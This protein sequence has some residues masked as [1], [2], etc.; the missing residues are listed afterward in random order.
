MTWTWRLVSC[1]P[2]GE[3]QHRYEIPHGKTEI[4]PYPVDENITLLGIRPNGETQIRIRY[5]SWF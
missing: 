2:P 3:Y 4:F 1:G 5:R